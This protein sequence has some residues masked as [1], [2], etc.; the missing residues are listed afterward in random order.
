MFGEYS[1]EE[2]EIMQR[3]LL[4]QEGEIFSQTDYSLGEQKIIQGLI[5]PIT[6]D[7]WIQHL[8]N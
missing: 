7:T 5:L 6:G 2:Q 8:P 1:L 3:F 4:A